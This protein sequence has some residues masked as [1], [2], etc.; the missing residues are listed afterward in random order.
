MPPVRFQVEIV[1][2]FCTLQAWHEFVVSSLASSNLVVSSQR[3]P[4]IHPFHMPVAIA[5]KMGT[6]RELKLLCTK[7]APFHFPEAGWFTGVSL[8]SIGNN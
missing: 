3:F 6:T 8:G 7:F 2:C 1:S 5:W 4:S